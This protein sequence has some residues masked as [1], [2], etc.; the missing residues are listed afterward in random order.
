MSV[1]NPGIGD[2]PRLN[3]YVQLPPVHGRITR[4]PYARHLYLGG[5]N[6]ACNRSTTCPP[7]AN[8]AGGLL[9]YQVVKELKIINRNNFKTT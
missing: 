1:D 4:C 7:E 3:R 6:A 2:T 5:L 8:Q 9:R